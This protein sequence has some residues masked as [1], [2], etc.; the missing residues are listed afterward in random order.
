MKTE[1]EHFYF[2]VLYRCESVRMNEFESSR[3]KKK[4]GVNIEF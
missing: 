4:D 3:I 1:T 2:V